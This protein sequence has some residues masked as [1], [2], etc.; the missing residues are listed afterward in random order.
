MRDRAVVLKRLS[1][2]LAL[3]LAS[4]MAT[5]DVAPD[6]AHKRVRLGAPFS[7]GTVQRAIDGARRRL[8]HPG[9]QRVFTDFH[10]A[11]GRPLQDVLDRE[12]TSGEAVLGRLIFYDGSGQPRCASRA[13]LAFTWPSSQIVFVCAEQ[14]TATAHRDPLMAEAAL[15]HESLHSLGLGENPPSSSTITARVLSRCRG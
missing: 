10:D 11:S 13:T 9:C 6:P 2:G 5:A 4:S 12:D 14:F 1:A 3:A 8:G 7:A 15:I